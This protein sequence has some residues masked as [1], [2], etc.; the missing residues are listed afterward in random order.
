MDLN[1]P[2]I[3]HMAI[4]IETKPIPIFKLEDKDKKDETEFAAKNLVEKYYKAN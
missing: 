1:L 3:F 4:L 2:D